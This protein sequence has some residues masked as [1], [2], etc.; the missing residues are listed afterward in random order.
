M[1][2]E[3]K[4][5]EAKEKLYDVK[6]VKKKLDDFLAGK[7]ETYSPDEQLNKVFELALKLCAGPA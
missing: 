2:I 6:A 4:Y 5:N 7:T 3:E 1:S